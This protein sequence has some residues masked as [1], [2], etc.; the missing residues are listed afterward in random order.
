MT[1]FFS[2]GRQVARAAPGCPAKQQNGLPRGLH[3]NRAAKF[4]AAP[5]TKRRRRSLAAAARAAP[6]TT[7]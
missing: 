5:R 7:Q 3:D 2:I 4:V 1:W 6:L